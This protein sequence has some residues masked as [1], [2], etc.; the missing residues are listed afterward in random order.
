M[1]AHQHDHDHEHVHGPGCG[2][3]HEHD[4]DAESAERDEYRAAAFAQVRQFGDPILRTPTLAVSRF[5]D[6]LRDQVARMVEIMDA[7][8]G[9]GIAA[10]QVGSLSRVA[11]MLLDD[12]HEEL[13]V[14]CNPRIVWRSEREEEGVEG[15]LSI[16]MASIAVNVMRADAV[17]VEAQDLDG[18][19]L[20]IEAEGYAARIVQHEVDHLDGVL[21]IDRTGAEERRE[22]L[23]TLRSRG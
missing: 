8:G 21:M 22:A 9:V 19:P 1:A 14:L 6:D 13:T 12:E 11:V 17:R 16:G 23:R 10:P 15:C 20:E 4:H 7:A 2:H 18:S 5:D 3:D